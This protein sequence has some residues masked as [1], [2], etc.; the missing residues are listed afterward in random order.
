MQKPEISFHLLL[1]RMRK[2]KTVIISWQNSGRQEEARN[3]TNH[4]GSASFTGS[5]SDR[6]GVELVTGVG[7]RVAGL[8]STNK[9]SDTN[10]GR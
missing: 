8:D 9:L 6:V 4:T 3:N 10:N 7:V 2:I 1:K 5:V